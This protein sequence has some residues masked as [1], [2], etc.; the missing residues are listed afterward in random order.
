MKRLLFAFM[1]IIPV[2]LCT[3]GTSRGED[4][5]GK[6]GMAMTLKGVVRG[7]V[8]P[9]DAYCDGYGNPGASGLGYIS[10]LKLQTGKVRKDMDTV[11]E[12]IVSYDRAETLGTYVG[13]INMITASSFNG[14]NGAVWGYHVAKAGSIADG[15]LKP[16]F[17][18]RRSDGVEIPVYSVDPLLDAGQRLFGTAGSR[19]FPI[20]PGAH[21]KCA[22]KSKTVKGPT[23]VWC[24]IAL[25]IAE[26]RQKDSNL[27]IED[28]GDSIPA[29]SEEARRA[30]LDRLLR[31]IATS[32]IRCG[33]DS[34]VKYKAIFVGYRT[35]WIP[36]GYVG[37]ALTCAPYV[38][39]AKNALPGGGPEQ[40]LDMT[41]SDWEKALHLPNLR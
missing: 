16:L 19:R 33:D 4:A 28:A 6:K 3:A 22:V 9:F 35:E 14:I 24:A 27:F 8:G 37:C 29:E 12:G 17:K 20:L 10:V 11:L 32:I 2:C 31:N 30:Y 23:S 25:A 40:L 34:H 18:S 7:A 13:Q 38:V 36:E 5:S 21:V 39:L 15:S 26:D 1:L 41:I